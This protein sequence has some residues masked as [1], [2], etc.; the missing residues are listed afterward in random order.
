MNCL[1]FEN[2]HTREERKQVDKLAPI[3]QIF[4]EFVSCCK[5]SYRHSELVT[6]DE[7]LEAFRSKCSLRQYMPKKP[8]KYDIKI[9]ALCD[10]KMW[11]TSSMEVYVGQQPIGPC[12]MENSAKAI[13][14]KLTEH[15]NG[16]N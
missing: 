16:S 9:F 10:A 3:R 1:R 2:I 5:S 11:Y 8:N 12:R 6:I 7:K 13:I 14:A 15:I 4:D